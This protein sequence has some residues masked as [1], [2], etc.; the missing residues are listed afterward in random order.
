[1]A[2]RAELDARHAHRAVLADEAV[3]ELHRVDRVLV[4]EE[5]DRARCGR[6]PMEHPRMARGPILEQRPPFVDEEP[7]AFEELLAALERDLGEPLR[8][9]GRRDRRVVLY[10]KG[11]LDALARPDHPSDAQPRKPVDL[12]EPAR[13]EDPFAASAERRALLRG[14]FRAAVDLV[15]EDPRAMLIGDA[16]DALDLGL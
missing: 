13:H 1:M 3:D 12:R 5:T 10:L 8:Q 11:G 7:R 9:R 4:A 14:A 16:H 2:L 6:R 15:R